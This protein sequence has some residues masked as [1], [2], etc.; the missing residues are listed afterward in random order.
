MRTLNHLSELLL[1]PA[2]GSP[3]AS[4]ITLVSEDMEE[5]WRPSIFKWFKA[6]LTHDLFLLLSAE[7]MKMHTDGSSTEKRHLIYSGER[8]VLEQALGMPAQIDFSWLTVLERTDAHL[9][10]LIHFFTN[11][12]LWRIFDS[13]S[14]LPTIKVNL[15][16][17]SSK[18][19]CVL[20]INKLCTTAWFGPELGI[21]C[22]KW[23][24]AAKTYGK[25]QVARDSEG[26]DGQYLIWLKNHLAFFE[27]CKNRIKLF[28]AWQSL[29]LEL[30]LRYH[31]TPEPFN[32]GIY[33]VKFSQ[34]QTIFN[35]EWCECDQNSRF[36]PSL[37]SQG[38]SFRWTYSF[39]TSPPVASSPW[40]SSQHYRPFSQGSKKSLP[41]CCLLCGG[42][43]HS[44][45]THA[46]DGQ[47]QPFPMVNVCGQASMVGS[48]SQ[49]QVIRSASFTTSEGVVPLAPTEMGPTRMLMSVPSVVALPIMPS[50]RPARNALQ[51]DDVLTSLP[52]LLEYPDLAQTIKPRPA[53]DPLLHLFP[54]IFD[55]QISAGCSWSNACLS[56][57]CP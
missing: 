56:A 36:L 54:K 43:G 8:E 31:S 52:P 20:D 39:T 13:L 16:D 41:S 25:Y 26:P 12:N 17:D 19:T 57:S 49:A 44:A 14:T 21:S 45:D 11:K 24:E 29:E 3:E 30:C 37:F 50:C 4:L 9:P 18:A 38:N 7:M 35:W 51:L 27:N 47:P 32:S 33:Y 6:I 55:F 53:F 40:S 2:D 23:T 42:C 1:H 34:C 46:G 10:V 48:F 28:K 22:A 15:L 5:L